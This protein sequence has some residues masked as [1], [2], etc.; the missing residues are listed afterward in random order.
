M[1]RLVQIETGLTISK[2][3]LKLNILFS[4]VAFELSYQV[5]CFGL[6]YH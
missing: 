3:N 6:D 5:L 2:A 1:G 4:H